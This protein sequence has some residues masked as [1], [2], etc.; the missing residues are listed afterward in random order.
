[1]FLSFPSSIVAGQVIDEC[2]GV[3]VNWNY[4]PMVPPTRSFVK[5]ISG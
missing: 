5:D 2:L 4:N 3:I 1:M